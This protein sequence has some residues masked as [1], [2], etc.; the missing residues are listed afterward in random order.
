MKS[1]RIS[2]FWV[3]GYHP[4]S[5]PGLERAVKKMLQ[6]EICNRD[7]KLIDRLLKAAKLRYK[8]FIEDIFADE[9]AKARLGGT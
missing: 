3:G 5:A 7:R 1:E 4:F 9:L 8:V 6:T 2:P